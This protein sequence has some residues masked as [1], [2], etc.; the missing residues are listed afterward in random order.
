MAKAFSTSTLIKGK[1]AL[2]RQM[3]CEVRYQD[4]QLY[5]DRCGRLLKTLLSQAPEWVVGTEPTT[6]GT[7]VYDLTT[8]TQ[9]GLSM[10]SASLSLDRSI[11][12]EVI[13]EEEADRFLEQIDSVLQLVLDEFEIADYSRVG[14][15][16]HYYFAFENK[17]DSEKWLQELGLIQVAS[18][19]Y[20]AFEATH[21]LMSFIVGMQGPT[22]RYQITLSGI[23]RSAQVPVSA[24]VLNVRT[25]AVPKNQKKLLLESMKKQRQRQINSAFAVV[26]DIDAFLVDPV[27]LDLRN[28]VQE[29]ARMGVKRFREALPK[30][31]PKKGK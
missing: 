8:G 9:L 24:A 26:L 1:E 30:D 4:G 2:L 21:D 19:L 29:H 23:E 7:I 11:T 25:S 17:D 5:L 22:C 15:R 3:V 13:T 18:S 16:E 6:K 12:D 10:A 27:E 31:A 28:Y 20:Q 14:Y